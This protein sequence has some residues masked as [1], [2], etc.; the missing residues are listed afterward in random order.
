MNGEGEGDVFVW[1]WKDKKFDPL[2]GSNAK[3]KPIEREGG[4]DVK[5]SLAG[6]SLR[7]PLPRYG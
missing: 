4:A 6:V 7:E 3:K 5:S 2:I 1:V